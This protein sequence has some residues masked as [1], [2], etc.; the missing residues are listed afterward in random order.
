MYTGIFRVVRNQSHNHELL[1]SS[2][3]VFLSP[4]KGSSCKQ[5][6]KACC[7]RVQGNNKTMNVTLG[8]SVKEGKKKLPNKNVKTISHLINYIYIKKVNLID[9]ADKALSRVDWDLQSL[10]HSSSR[11]H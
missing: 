11:Q 2:F 5:Q 7:G 4:C 6:L 8:L 9:V 10:V 1:C 3:K